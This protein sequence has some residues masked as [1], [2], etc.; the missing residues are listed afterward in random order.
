MNYS[1]ALPHLCGITVC[2]FGLASLS[3]EE[4]LPVYVAPANILSLRVS[5]VEQLSDRQAPP[6]H[7]AVHIQLVGENIFDEVFQDSVDIKGSMRIWWKRKPNRYRTLFL[8]LKDFTSRQ[9]IH[10][11][12]MLL[13]PRQQFTLDIV[14]N[15]KTDDSTYCASVNEMNYAYPDERICDYN[16]ICSDPEG[17]V[18]ESSLNVYDRL[19]YITAEPKEFSVVGH[20]CD[21]AGKGPVCQIAAPSKRTRAV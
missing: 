1:A 9:L 4:K 21:Q 6:G 14:W 15:L 3:C 2:M 5:K 11:G 20:L 19:G 7:Q 18:V 12:R 16:I 13:L 10:N 8:T 17:F